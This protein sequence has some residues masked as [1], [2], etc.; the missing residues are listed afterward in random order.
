MTCARD[1]P[2]PL[3]FELTVLGPG[4]GES[5]VLHLGNNNWIVIDSFLGLDKSPVALLYLQ[6]IGVE[7][8]NIKLILATH[9]HDDHIKGLAEMVKLCPSARFYCA[10]AFTREEFL[11]MVSAL[12]HRNDSVS[13]SGVREITSVLT[14]LVDG[15]RSVHHAIANRL[16]YRDGMCEVIALSPSDAYFQKF[17]RSI[18]ELIPREGEHK[19]R[20]PPLS[21]NDMAVA[22]FIEVG[23]F[24][25]LLGWD[26][27]KVGWAAILE[28]EPRAASKASV[29][30]VPHHGSHNAHEYRVWEELLENNPI[31]VVTPWR[32][33]RS[34]LPRASDVERICAA[35]RE[36]WIT[37]TGY[38]NMLNSS[39]K[40]SV[41]ARTLREGGVRRR[42]LAGDRDFVRLRREMALDSDWRVECSGRACRLQ[43]FPA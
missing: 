30:K 24:S 28:N 2:N 38:S 41:V 20:L 12:E 43:D 9:W 6:S 39:H 33:G 4:Y 1:A 27:E 25:V 15:N 16:V 11:G 22:L 19:K 37:S 42:L 14:Q 8:S 31:A 13:G 40:N 3:D 23:E 35:T 5:I 34:S 17:L 32:R 7:L 21:Q 26:L 10:S 36:A 18:A 29:F